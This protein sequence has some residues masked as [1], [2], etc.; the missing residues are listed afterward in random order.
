MPQRIEVPGIGL[1]EFPDGMSDAEIV[2]AIQRNGKRNA[3][4]DPAVT[5]RNMAERP[6]L[7]DP[8]YKY[9][10]GAVTG[11]EKAKELLGRGASAVVR[12]LAQAIA[13]PGNLVTDAAQSYGWLARKGIASMTGG[14]Q[15]AA[16]QLQSQGFNSALDSVTFAPQTTMG[17]VNEMAASALIGSR[18]PLPQMGKRAPESFVRPAAGARNDVLR[19]AQR[20]G[21]VVP[22]SAANP[23]LGN[24]LME[25]FAGKVKLGQ[26]AALRNQPITDRLIA[27]SVGETSGVPV[28]Q[29]ALQNIRATAHAAGYEPVRA[30]G[31]ITTDAKYVQQL[32][33]ITKAAQG[34]SRSFPGISKTN[35]IDDVVAALSQKSFDA[36]DGIDALAYLRDEADTAYRA[37]N[38]SLGK[39]YKAAS[40]AVEDM[41]E[42]DLSGRGADGKEILKR[43]RDARTLM[44]KTYTAG[45]AEVGDVGQFN[46][47]TFAAELAKGKPLTGEQKLVGN[48]AGSF[49]KYTPRPSGEIFPDIS[50]LDVYGSAGVSAVADSALPF[51]YPLS[52]IGMRQYL[53]SQAGQARAIPAPYR[54]PTNL[55]AIG[56]AA[57]LVSGL[58]GE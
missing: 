22:P 47:R 52:R 30:A 20:E 46:A 7:Y 14:Q 53:L 50:P 3:P 51:A 49:G 37:G 28:T 35:P 57:P 9:Q 12:P 11:G 19:A 16:P 4:R 25:G 38:S 18:I 40:K 8:N 29:G 42:R 41:I 32:Q 17:R 48:F 33:G 10:P 58:F 31:V 1:V 6:D 55:G 27:R 34:A 2:A 44:A 39:A 24:R 13:A 23:T 5:A 54:I 36:G 15:P 26:A 21:Y 45:K 43:F 56:A